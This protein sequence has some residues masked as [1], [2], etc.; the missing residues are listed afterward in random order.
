MAASPLIRGGCRALDQAAGVL[1]SPPIRQLATIGGN[2]GRGSPASDLTPALMVC[3]ATVTVV[4]PGT[5]REIPVEDLP[6]GPGATSL[7][8]GE[9]ITTVLIPDAGP[10]TGS[11][12][13]KLGRRGGGWDLALVG[14]AASLTLAA[15]GTVAAARIALASVGPTVL[16]G[17][18]AEGCLQGRV[19]DEAALEAAA[20][21]AA[22]EARPISDVRATGDY[23]RELTRVLALRAL[24]AARGAALGEGPGP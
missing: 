1:G 4:G 10:R 3:G 14:V 22:A 24:R 12:H 5:E 17:R 7:R 21:A 19:P 6:I 16:R 13:L 9:I 11:A 18:G 20:E 8:C 15:D 23:R 2:L